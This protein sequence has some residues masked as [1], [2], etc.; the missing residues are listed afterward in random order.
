MSRKFAHLLPVD[1]EVWER[2]LVKHGLEYS[3]LEYDIR[4]GLGRDPGGIYPENIRKMAF[5]LS[6][7]RIDCV[8]HRGDSITVI[9]I[10]HSA[11]FKALGQIY[12]YPILYTL[13]FQPHLPI[14]SLLV[15]G[16]IQSDIVPVLDSLGV[17]YEVV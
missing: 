9:E 4:V 5:D 8:A 10:T 7:R 1:V 16:E 17:K 11:G 12:G 6:Y 15:C 13:T 14:K 3:L 2:F